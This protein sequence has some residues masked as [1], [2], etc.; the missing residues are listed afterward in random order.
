MPKHI[1]LYL[2][3]SSK[4]QD[5]KS[6][7]PDLLKWAQLHAD[8][9][10]TVMYRDSFTGTTMDRKGWNRLRVA[11]AEHRARLDRKTRLREQTVGFVGRKIAGTEAAVEPFETD[12]HKAQG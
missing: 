6:Q 4:Q 11:V 12:L 3:V 9:Q 2:R 7:S 10:P 8:G 5:T 1:A